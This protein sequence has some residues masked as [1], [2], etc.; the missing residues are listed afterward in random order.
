MMK[1]SFLLC[2]IG[3]TSFG[4]FAQQAH[5][6]VVQATASEAGAQ[7]AVKTASGAFGGNYITESRFAKNAKAT[8]AAFWTEDFS[9]G[10][11]TSL[12]AGW[13][14]IV[15]SGQIGNWRWT[16]IASPGQYNIGALNSTTA[17]NGWMIFDGDSVGKLQPTRLPLQGSL[18]SPPINCAAHTSVMATFQQLFRKFRDSTYL[19]VSNDGGTTWTT[20]P[21][22]ANNSMSDNSINST[23]PSIIRINITATAASQANVKLRFRYED[24]VYKTG[25]YNWLVDDVALTELDPVELGI[26]SSGIYHINGPSNQYSGWSLFSSIPL[27]LADSMLPITFLANY[28]LNPGINVNT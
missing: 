8:A 24:N 2:A 13:S 5:R 28:G 20:Y 15:P 19:D 25:S 21:I 14:A 3:L 10:T 9:T 1:K 23:N 6:S 12:P 26:S 4:A 22:L 18:I 17:S 7:A 27:Q 16:K 11:A